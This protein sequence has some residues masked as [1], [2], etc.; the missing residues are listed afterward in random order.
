MIT[1]RTGLPLAVGCTGANRQESMVFEAMI[2]AIPPI[3]Q[4]RGGRR[5]RPTKLHADEAYDNPRCRAFLRQRRITNRIARIGI[6]S[7]TKLGRHRWVVERTFAWLHQYRRLQVRYERRA[8]I[9]HAFLTLAGTL[10][11]FHALVRF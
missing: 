6:E 4:P 7:K 3:K 5:H 1:E 11:C 8:D 2:D 10:I 9:H